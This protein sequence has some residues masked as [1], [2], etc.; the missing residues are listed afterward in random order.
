NIVYLP[1]DRAT[2]AAMGG[3]PLHPQVSIEPIDRLMCEQI[4]QFY[5]Q[6]KEGKQKVDAHVREVGISAAHDVLDKFV[7]YVD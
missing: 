5:N 4:G 3:L 2:Q 1:M 7:T 6:F